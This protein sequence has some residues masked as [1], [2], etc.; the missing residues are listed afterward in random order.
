[1]KIVVAGPGCARCEATEKNVKE[2]CSD[3]TL[4]A[5]V[6]HVYDVKEYGKLG[7]RLTPAVIVDGEIAFSGR[8]PTVDEIKKVLSRAFSTHIGSF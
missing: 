7:V 2:A 3:L 4:E 8:V 6:E 5:E 1:M